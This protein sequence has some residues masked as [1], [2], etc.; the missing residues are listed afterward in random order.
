[1]NGKTFLV[2]SLLLLAVIVSAVAMWSD[3]LR[4]NGVVRTGDVD[5]AFTGYEVVEGEEY[6]KPWVASCSAQLVEVQ[7][8]DPNNPAGNNDLDLKIVISNV[9]PGYSCS[10]YFKVKNTGTVPVIGPFYELPDIPEGIEVVFEPRLEQLHP[11]DEVEYSIGL[12]VLQEAEQGATYEVQV[13]LQYIQWNEVAVKYATISGYI[14]NDADGDG[15]WDAGEDPLPGVL[16]K[17]YD[18]TGNLVGTYCSGSDGFYEFNVY[19]LTTRQYTIVA[20]GLPNYRFTTPS[21]IYSTVWPGS[22][23]TNNNFGLKLEQVPPAELAASKEFRHTNTNFNKCPAS[24]GD[25]LNSVEVEVPD[26]GKDAG[27]IKNVEPGAFFSVIQISGEG[28]SSINITD[29]YDFH[30]DIEDSRDG[31]VRVYLLDSRGCVTELDPHR[32]SYT[33]DNENNVVTVNISLGRAL[34][35]GETILVYLKF[36][37]AGLVGRSWDSLT[38]GQ[39]D[40]TATVV[41]NIGSR[42]VAASVLIVKK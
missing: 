33:V 2:T 32:Y 23:S 39:F 42:T 38:D 16:V 9:Y 11:G 36:K 30:F 7:D 26:K 17:L 13:H 28:I 6:G 22:S 35:T 4:V 19:P 5:V 37:D 21:T 10:V 20:Y 12:E 34:G 29:Q 31:R 3:V 41:T 40:N 27:K 24:L 15:S 1:M 14:F 25:P 18:D 8:E